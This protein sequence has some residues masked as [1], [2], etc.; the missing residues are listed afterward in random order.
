MDA[1]GKTTERLSG[2]WSSK[3]EPRA[4]D[5]AD[6]TAFKAWLEMIAALDKIFLL[7]RSA[8][9]PELNAGFSIRCGQEERALS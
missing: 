4:R 9:P 1:W 6:V 5:V 2:G 7:D 3:F 8:R